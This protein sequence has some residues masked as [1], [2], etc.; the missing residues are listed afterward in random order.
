MT[1]DG[2]HIVVGNHDDHSLMPDTSD[3]SSLAAAAETHEGMVKIEN[4]NGFSR[5]IILSYNLF[6]HRQLSVSDRDHQNC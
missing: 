4:F 3:L 1:H 6:K 5:T 2:Q